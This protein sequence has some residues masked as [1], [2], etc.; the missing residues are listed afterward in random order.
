[1]TTIREKIALLQALEDMIN[2]ANISINCAQQNVIDLAYSEELV[3][4]ESSTLKA[5]ETIVKHLEKL[6]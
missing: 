6:I 1:M 5:F 4:K 2:Y 3:E